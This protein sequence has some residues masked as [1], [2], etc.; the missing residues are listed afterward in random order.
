MI[1][2]LTTTDHVVRKLTEGFLTARVLEARA[3]GKKDFTL[4][5][6]IGSQ[7]PSEC[8]P[9]RTLYKSNRVAG[10]ELGKILGNVGRKLGLQVKRENKYGKKDAITRYFV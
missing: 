1:V 3:M 8:A 7:W 2:Q 5:E 6:L 9:F 4:P 10:C